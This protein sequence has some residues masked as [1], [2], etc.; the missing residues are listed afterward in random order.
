MDSP[1]WSRRWSSLTLYTPPIDYH[2]TYPPYRIH[3]K[4]PRIYIP[5]SYLYYPPTTMSSVTIQS[6]P[7][8]LTKEDQHGGH[9]LLLESLLFLFGFIFFPAWWIGVWVYYYR[10]RVR[11][12][13]VQVQILAYLNGLLSIVSIGLM[14]VTLVLILLI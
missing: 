1:S 13:S 14:I 4:P 11:G 7:P 3:K 2:K 6:M 8:T 9:D 10:I 5:S 12:A